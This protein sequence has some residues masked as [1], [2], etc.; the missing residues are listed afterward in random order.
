MVS[1]GCQLHGQVTWRRSQFL[2]FH[3]ITGLTLFLSGE[4]KI[5]KKKKK[6]FLLPTDQFFFQHISGNTAIFYALL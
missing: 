4:K 5:E 3:K 2:Y 1:C 6:K